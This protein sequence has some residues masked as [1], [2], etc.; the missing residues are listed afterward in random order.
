MIKLQL[1][2]RHPSPDITLDPGVRALLESHGLRV[3]GSGRASVSAE[4]TEEDF[5]ALFGPAPPSPDLALPAGLTDAVSLV[6]I[7]PRHSPMHTN[8]RVNHAAI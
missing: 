7:A 2:L 8:P 6:S 5:H 3:T 4:M 1:L